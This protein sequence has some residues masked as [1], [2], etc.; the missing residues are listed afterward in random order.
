MQNVEEE[1]KRNIQVRRECLQVLTETLQ[2]VELEEM[3]RVQSDMAREVEGAREEQRVEFTRL[4][5]N[6]KSEMVLMQEQLKEYK[7]LQDSLQKEMASVQARQIQAL[8]ERDECDLMKAQVQG[9]LQDLLVQVEVQNTAT[10][11]RERAAVISEQAA[12]IAQLN[13]TIAAL[14][15]KNNELLQKEKSL[16]EEIE[17]CQKKLSDS[18]SSNDDIVRNLQQQCDEHLQAISKQKENNNTLKAELKKRA[19][20]ANA[21]KKDAIFSGELIM[22]LCTNATDKLV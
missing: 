6:V 8:A 4:Q 15:E 11:D 12:M 7:Q 2:A 20:A 13:D 10:H 9:C 3:D 14:N 16:Q 22:R 17:R 1:H 5:D 21:V 18:S 19:T